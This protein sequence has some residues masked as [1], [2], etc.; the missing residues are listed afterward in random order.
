MTAHLA[1]TAPAPK[2]VG[3]AASDAPAEARELYGLNRIAP[4]AQTFHRAPSRPAAR[5]SAAGRP[6]DS[7]AARKLLESGR[8]K[9][10]Y[11]AAG[12]GV[13]IDVTFETTEIRDALA[14][15]EFKMSEINTLMN[16]CINEAY[17]ADL[18]AQ[19]RQVKAQCVGLSYQILF[20]NY[21]EGVSKIRDILLELL[22]IKLQT[23][24]QDYE[25]ETNFFLDILENLLEKDFD[26]LPSLD[27][28]KKASRYYVSPNYYQRLVDVAMPEINAFNAIHQR[29]KAA[30]NSIQLTLDQKQKEDEAYLKQ[31]ED[32]AKSLE[33]QEPE[34]EAAEPEEPEEPENEEEEG[35]PAEDRRLNRRSGNGPVRR[36]AFAG[37]LRD[38]RRSRQ[39]GLAEE[40]LIPQPSR[41]FD[42]AI[43]PGKLKT[44]QSGSESFDP[45]GP[46]P[47][48]FQNSFDPLGPPP[49]DYQP[50]N[51]SPNLQPLPSS[52][53][54]PGLFQ[55][56][57]FQ[58]TGVGLNQRPPVSQFDMNQYLGKN[59]GFGASIGGGAP[60][61]SLV[62]GIYS[63]GPPLSSFA[64][65]DQ[66]NGN[67][68]NQRLNE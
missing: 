32:Q 55:T 38:P 5:R 51:F 33:Q 60:T 49:K 53:S 59:T 43:D 9:L 31:L 64:P 50:R 6:R 57:P 28:A 16:E 45:L 54:T 3:R 12:D 36:P 11:E 2:S 22:K 18:T 4:S 8:R 62:G 39:L 40:H 52:A 27:I 47:R 63:G 29:L 20:Y 58:P 21:R 14:F 34:P 23:L 46:P 7:E 44:L 17:E 42:S 19:A 68:Q 13:S 25:D 67:W 1:A 24:K 35:L 65:A 61:E 37:G 56:S 66:I 10:L 15:I 26:I 41:H 48:P 30:R